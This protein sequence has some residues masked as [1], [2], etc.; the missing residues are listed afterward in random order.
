M[1]E[2]ADAPLQRFRIWITGYDDWQP[3]DWHDVP[4]RA[5]ALEPAEAAALSAAQAQSFLEGFNRQML[6][7]RL[8]D[9]QEIEGSKGDGK[10]LRPAAR[11]WAVAVPVAVLY[12]GDAQ[13]G[14]SVSGH[15]F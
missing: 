12:E 11:L 15:R 5:I 3:T 2:P 7:D 6:H 8:S 13:S 9:G 14:E 1:I 10:Q 4:P